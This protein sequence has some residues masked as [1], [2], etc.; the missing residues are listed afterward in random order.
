[1]REK[2]Q[3]KS[4]DEELHHVVSIASYDTNGRSTLMVCGCARRL[5]H[6]SMNV[7]VSGL[8]D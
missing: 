7:Q 5:V 4:F 3:L 6:G 8:V 2:T 1:M